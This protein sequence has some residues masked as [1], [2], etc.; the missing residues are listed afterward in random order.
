MKSELK[1]SKKRNRISSENER[2]PNSVQ[3]HPE[4]SQLKNP[5]EA[6]S[7]T[8]IHRNFPGDYFHQRNSYE[9]QVK[10]KYEKNLE[11]ELDHG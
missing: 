11:S 6:T 2:S 5:D 8:E 10:V 7:F 9:N 4:N 3:R 1:T